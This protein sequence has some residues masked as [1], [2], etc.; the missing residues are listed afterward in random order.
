M[1]PVLNIDP[2]TLDLNRV[3]ADKEA[4]R[5]INP[6]RFEMEHLDAIVL[7]DTSQHMVAGYKES[8][9]TNS[10]FAATC[11]VIRYAGA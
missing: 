8:P 7:E 5:L 11:R 1:P 6:Q 2:A 4:I 9:T 10:G 3:I